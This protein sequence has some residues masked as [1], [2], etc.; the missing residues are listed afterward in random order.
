ME[1]TSEERRRQMEGNDVGLD[2]QSEAIA[3]RRAKLAVK[4]DKAKRNKQRAAQLAKSLDELR[5]KY[6]DMSKQ[7]DI[8][9]GKYADL[10][11]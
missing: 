5:A 9:S 8:A 7:K 10:A 11:G 6:E 4:T 2:A 1:E 3:E